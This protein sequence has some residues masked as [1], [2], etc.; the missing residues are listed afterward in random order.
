MVYPRLKA[1]S[2]QH[3]AVQKVTSG[4]AVSLGFTAALVDVILHER[5]HLLKLVL[6]L[7]ALR[8]G[9]GIQGSHDLQETRAGGRPRQCWA[10]VPTRQP[11]SPHQPS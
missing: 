6:E 3:C 4:A 10:G 7:C 1:G 11:S 9:V 2:L 8:R 5:N